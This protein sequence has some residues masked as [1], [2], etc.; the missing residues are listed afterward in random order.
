MECVGGSSVSNNYPPVVGTVLQLSSVTGAPGRLKGRLI[1]EV[2]PDSS[3]AGTHVITLSDSNPEKTVATPNNRPSWDPTDAYIGYD[4]PSNVNRARTQ[5]S[6]GAPVSISSYISNVGDGVNWLERLTSTGKTFRVPVSADGYRTN[7]NCASVAG[8]CG[9]ASAGRV[10]M[11]TGQTIMNVSTTAVDANSEINLTENFS[12]GPSLG[13]QCNKTLARH[14]AI[15]NQTPGVG[16]TI[17]TDKPPLG[18][19]ACLSFSV[20]NTTSRSRSEGQ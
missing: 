14:Y 15:L 5:L 6:L 10:V 2:P 20:L 18:N 12:Y 4:Q 11:P 8:E 13:V 7:S 16:F 3:V 9:D 19:P 17:T 1:F